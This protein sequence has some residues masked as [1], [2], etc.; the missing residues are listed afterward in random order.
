MSDLPCTD[1]DC[2][3]CKGDLSKPH[4]GTNA[5]LA[6]AMSGKRVCKNPNCP[7]CGGDRSKPH[8]RQDPVVTP[9]PPEA[10]K[11]S[12]SFDYFDADDR[13]IA[14]EEGWALFQLYTERSPSTPVIEI[15]RLDKFED[16]REPF[17]ENDDDA[18]DYVFLQAANGSRL[19]MRALLLHGTPVDALPSYMP[20]IT[21]KAKCQHRLKVGSVVEAPDATSSDFD[22]VVDVTC[23]NCGI[24]GSA[25]ITNDI[26]QWE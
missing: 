5:W 17:Y 12:H 2:L 25:R 16:G 18:I 11:Q 9:V 24:S 1:A 21:I 22:T 23:D 26:V 19:H 15:Q 14:V 10:K 20:G 7:R 13:K 8:A 3:R 6:P 4:T